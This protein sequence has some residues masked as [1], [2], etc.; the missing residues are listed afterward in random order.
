MNS[1]EISA[2]FIKTPK[3]RFVGVVRQRAP[4]EKEYSESRLPQCSEG[5][6]GLGV[7]PS[8]LIS[9]RSGGIRGTGRHLLHH[10]PSIYSPLLTPHPRRPLFATIEAIRGSIF[11]QTSARPLT[12]RELPLACGR[13]DGSAKE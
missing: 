9:R 12:P 2:Q 5:S 13:R 8:A 10:Q 6:I 1:A 3:V 4:L 7:P 11:P